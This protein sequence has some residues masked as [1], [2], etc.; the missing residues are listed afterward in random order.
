MVKMVV[1]IVDEVPKYRWVKLDVLSATSIWDSEKKIDDL[2]SS[3]TIARDTE[4]A[5]QIVIT[6]CVSWERVCMAAVE[7]SRPFTYFYEMLCR[8]LG[9]C[10]PL[11]AFEMQ[12]LSAVQ[13]APTQLHLNGWAFIRGFQIMC[14]HLEVDVSVEKFFYFF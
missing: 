3:L 5:D 11:T 4:S 13:V 8:T 14:K 12:L 1:Q 9:V 6:S 2:V 7:G 10:L